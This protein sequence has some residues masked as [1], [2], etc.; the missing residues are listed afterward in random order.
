MSP[1]GVG[2][3]CSE[4]APVMQIASTPASA[5]ALF[6]DMSASDAG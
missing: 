5:A 6:T 4:W 3:V 2:A 1:A